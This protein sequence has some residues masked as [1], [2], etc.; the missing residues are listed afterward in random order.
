MQS[1]AYSYRPTMF[2][3]INSRHSAT[4]RA[5]CFAVSICRWPIRRRRTSVRSRYSSRRCG[6]DRAP[7]LVLL[8][9]LPLV[10]WMWIVVMARDMYGPMTGASAW[11]M[12]AM[13]DVPHLLLLWAMWA[14]MMA[15]MML[16]SASPML[17]LYGVVARR[18]AAS[19]G[20]APYLRARGR[21]SDGLD[22]I[23]S[24]GNRPSARACCSLARLADDGDHEARSRCH[25]AVPRGPLPV[26]AVQARVPAEVPVTPWIPGEPLAHRILW[27][28]HV[29]ASS[30]VRIAWAVVGR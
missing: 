30:T 28:V 1:E 18:S 22:R 27:C 29:W 7:L 11:M 25:A 24:R 23:Q 15:G 9:L 5:R 6:Y 3:R 13:W 21:V 17:L 10:S 20:S 12:T 16:P 14:V 2:P 26:D 19:N 4:W 8:V